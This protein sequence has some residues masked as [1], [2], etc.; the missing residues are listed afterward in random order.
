M[1][2][3]AWLKSP[4]NNSLAF[5]YSGKKKNNKK[6]HTFRSFWLI[7]RRKI[8]ERLV[9]SFF[10]LFAAQ[11]ESFHGLL[12]ILLTPFWRSYLIANLTTSL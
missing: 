9:I 3:Q 1:V 5:I 11:I 6:T 10:E 12:L 7:D 2:S 4:V 8:K